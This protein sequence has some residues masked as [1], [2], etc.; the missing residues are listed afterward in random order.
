MLFMY[1]TKYLTSLI[2]IA[3]T[4]LFGNN[5]QGQSVEILSERLII[6]VNS[7]FVKGERLYNEICEESEEA[8]SPLP[9]SVSL[10]SFK[11]RLKVY[12]I[13]LQSQG[14]SIEWAPENFRLCTQKAKRKSPRLN[15][16]Q[17]T[18]N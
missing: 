7:I 13:T 10:G 9:T 16:N 5:T 4:N 1:K 17:T 8:N 2:P 14:N 11:N 18:D 3:I 6:Q 12:L 15:I